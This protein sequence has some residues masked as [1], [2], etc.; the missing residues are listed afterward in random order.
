[1][2]MPDSQKC[3][4]DRCGIAEWLSGAWVLEKVTQHGKVMFLKMASLTLN[5]NLKSTGKWMPKWKRC[6]I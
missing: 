3:K 1:M 2:I 4:F 6:C 5:S